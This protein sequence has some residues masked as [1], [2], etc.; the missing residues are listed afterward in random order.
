MTLAMVWCVN[1]VCVSSLVTLSVR[2]FRTST[3]MW[4]FMPCT[5]RMRVHG[6]GGGS[7]NYYIELWLTILFNSLKSGKNSSSVP[8]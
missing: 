2:M 7:S 5:M 8:L 3:S 6:W 4:C 1:V